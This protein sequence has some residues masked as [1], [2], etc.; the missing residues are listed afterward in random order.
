MKN[1]WPFT[2]KESL[3]KNKVCMLIL[4]DVISCPRVM[5]AAKSLSGKYDIDVVGWLRPERRENFSW[6]FAKAQ[7]FKLHLLDLWSARKMPKNI[8][9]YMFR[10][11]ES[12]VR[13]VKTARTLQASVIHAHELNALLAG[14]VLKKLTG[15]KLIY[16]AYELYRDE[17]KAKGRFVV[18][19][20]GKTEIFLMK[21][22]DMIIACNKQRA[23]IMYNEYHAPFEPK[24][25]RNLPPFSKPISNGKLREFVRQKNP[26]IERLIVHPGGIIGRGVDV[27]LKALAKTPPD[28]ALVLIGYEAMNTSE[29]VEQ[30]LKELK[31]ENRF[32][33]HPRVPY[34]E[35]LDYVCSADLGLVIYPNTDRNNYY[36]ASNKLYEYAMCGL[37]VVAVDFPP[38]RAV[39]E[40]Y[41]YGACFQW[42]D[43]DS[44][45]EA[46]MKCLGNKDQYQHMV[47]EASRA[48]RNENWD[49]EQKRLVKLY[50]ELCSR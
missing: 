1:F 11:V 27:L 34:T 18:G 26:D 36:C 7:P 21:R 16:D 3:K 23:D 22:C 49:I 43:A 2:S 9:G 10:Y 4:D 35:L 31:I 33:I 44:L 42:D 50:D 19:L 8:V 20:V 32:F 41:N 14:Y 40:E 38:C 6:E 30:K 45:A 13:M 25:I 29:L 37:P 28:V 12:L 15:A 5:R 46:I 47:V 17:L 24:I 48:A 39:L